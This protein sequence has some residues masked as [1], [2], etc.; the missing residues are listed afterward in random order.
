MRLDDLHGLSP[1]EIEA[2]LQQFVEDSYNPDMQTVSLEN[3]RLKI[4]KYEQTH[5]L[6]TAQAR[7]ALKD[8]TLQ[9]NGAVCNWMIE[10]EL[11]ESVTGKLP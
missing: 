4:V 1:E 9:E 3:L 11:Y 7:E 5:N 2:K 6:T 10:A 8:G